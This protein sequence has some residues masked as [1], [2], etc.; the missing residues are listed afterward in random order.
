MER[1]RSCRQKGT[2]RLA[3][4]RFLNGEV[5]KIFTADTKGHSFSTCKMPRIVRDPATGRTRHQI[6]LN[7]ICAKCQAIFTS[8][9]DRKVYPCGERPKPRG[10]T[11][12][13]VALRLARS[14][15][16]RRIRAPPPSGYT[17][18]EIDDMYAVA[19]QVL[20]RAQQLQND[21]ATQQ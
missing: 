13:G 7:K 19:I 17:S 6:V 9:T 15:R 21:A 10:Q 14:K 12:G 4:H 1:F 11:A 18:K 16:D 2:H 3:S 5:A 8:I 20:T